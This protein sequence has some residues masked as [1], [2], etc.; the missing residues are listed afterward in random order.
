M[1]KN[2]GIIICILVVLYLLYNSG[3][4]DGITTIT[5]EEVEQRVQEELIVSDNYTR[6]YYIASHKEYDRLREVYRGE[7]GMC[8]QGGNNRG[9]RVGEY[10]SVTGLGEGY[11]WCAAFVCWSLENAS[12]VHTAS[13][14]SPTTSLYNVVYSKGETF[15]VSED[16]LVFG[17][18][19]STLGRIGHTG[20][21]D[22]I[23]QDYSYTVEGNTSD[24][25]VREGDCV[26]RLKRPN[27]SF[28]KISKYDKVK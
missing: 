6:L 5:E 21:I 19:Y 24:G 15:P 26:H 2:T 28:Y 13:A 14:W 11:A 17:L 22:E 23:H 4:F 10:L 27:W 20:F 25:K 3:R 12:F 7:I 9:K 18:Y 16:G 8:E 1:G